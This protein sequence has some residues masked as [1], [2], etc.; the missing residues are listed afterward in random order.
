MDEAT[1][2]HC[3]RKWHDHYDTLNIPQALAERK[4]F[5]HMI[6][7]RMRGLVPNG[8]VTFHFN[9]GEYTGVHD[10]IDKANRAKEQ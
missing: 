5:L 8:S 7:E 3:R 2:Q 6:G 4:T 9:R 10:V 1:L